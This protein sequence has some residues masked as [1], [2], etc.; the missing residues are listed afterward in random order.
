MDGY[1]PCVSVLSPIQPLTTVVAVG[2]KFP[3]QRYA[4]CRANIIVAVTAKCGTKE[5]DLHD[6]FCLHAK[7]IFLNAVRDLGEMQI[8]PDT[9]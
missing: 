3:F 8:P 4:A 1:D 7:S 6:R 9:G 5:H 2:H